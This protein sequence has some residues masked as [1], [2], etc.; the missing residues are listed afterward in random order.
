[1]KV[2]VRCPNC[3]ALYS[4]PQD[5]IGKH[6]TCKN[7]GTSFCLA[8]SSTPIGAPPP[9]TNT[10]CQGE[11]Q[12]RITRAGTNQASY[13]GLRSCPH[14]RNRVFFGVNRLCPICGGDWASNATDTRSDTGPSTPGSSEAIHS[15]QRQTT[16]SL[17]R[18]PVG[19]TFSH[20]PQGGKSWHETKW[21][22]ALLGLSMGAILFGAF[23]GYFFVQTK[24]A[25]NLAPSLPVFERIVAQAAQE[26]KEKSSEPLSLGDPTLDSPY[27][28]KKLVTL[29]GFGDRLDIDEVFVSLESDRIARSAD[30]VGTIALLIYGETAGPSYRAPGSYES[31]ADSTR[32]TCIVI[33]IDAVAQKIVGV[34]EVRASAPKHVRPGT[35]RFEVKDNLIRFLNTIPKKYGEESR[36]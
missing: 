2:H 19:G 15:G 20:A 6:A 32:E 30:E 24:P 23:F 3:G 18:E 12:D 31:H 25:R 35:H 33:I 11:A 9:A 27:L 8:H 5:A 28:R 29:K 22:G 14:C 21:G 16:P 10:V 17:G 13:E 7:C 34:S 36:P 1:M 26:R 4:V